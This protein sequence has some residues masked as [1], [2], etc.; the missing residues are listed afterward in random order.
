VLHDPEIVKSLSQ[1]ALQT[2]LIFWR[3]FEKS[4][5]KLPPEQRERFV[6]LSSEI[7][8]VGHEFVT[9][10]SAPRPPVKIKPSELE[11]L[12]DQGMGARLQR[13]AWFTQK[14]LLV[15]P[16][17]HQAHMIMRAAP[18][19]EPRR[20]VY[21][22]AHASSPEQ[23]ERLERLLGARAQLSRL[24]GWDSYA[25]MTLNDKMAK[26][27]GEQLRE[28]AC[29]PVLMS[30]LRR[31][32]QSIF[33]YFLGSNYAC[34]SQSLAY[35]EPAEASTYKNDEAPYYPGMG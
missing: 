24:V 13:Q 22:A 2:A 33:G 11:G 14:D 27:P 7:L 18:D 31:K 20:K 34:C 19:E 25:G 6:S 15:Y 28:V 35:L 26:T 29:R 5:I 21:M 17:S 8:S 32:C 1:E 16:G 12:K 3:D 9:E 10:A 30:K 4:A 23:I